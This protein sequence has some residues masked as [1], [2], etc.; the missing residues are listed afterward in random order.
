MNGK[1]V[2]FGHVHIEMLPLSH[3][4]VPQRSARCPQRTRRCALGEEVSR[5]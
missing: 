3:L 2:W 4:P 1:G 5:G